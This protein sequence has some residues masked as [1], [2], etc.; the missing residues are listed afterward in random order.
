MAVTTR[1]R[2]LGLAAACAPRLLHPAGRATLAEMRRFCRSL[3]QLLQQPLPTAMQQISPPPAGVTPTPTNEQHTR[4]LADL[5]ALLERRS[6]LGLCLRRSLVRYHYLR[7]LG[8]PVTV[9]F[10]ARFA[11]ASPSTPDSPANGS[12]RIAGHAWLL[13][14]DQPYHEDEANWRD[15]TPMFRWP[16]DSA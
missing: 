1:L 16:P 10:G 5:A 11:P 12:R 13:L 9:Q 6:P 8:L 14:N 2:H 3:P 15:F 7:R 4:Q